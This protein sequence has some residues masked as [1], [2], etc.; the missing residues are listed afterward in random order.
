[1]K[2]EREEDDSDSTAMPPPS[3]P[4]PSTPDKFPPPSAYGETV[5]IKVGTDRTKTFTV[6]KSI[7]T[8]YSGYFAAAFRHGNAFQEA[9]TGLFNLPDEDVRTFEKFV[10]WLYSRRIDLIASDSSFFVLSRLW[11]LG[12]RRQVPLLMNECINMFRDMI[13]RMWKIPTA[14]LPLIYENTMD[15]SALRQFALDI[16]AKTGT[17][18]FLKEGNESFVKE[19]L[20]DILKI[21]WQDDHK[22]WAKHDVEK[23]QLCPQYHVHEEGVTCKKE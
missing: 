22:R 3:T 1:M 9:E 10:C 15:S 19:A 21:V 17:A 4:P 8:F 7:L 6:H 12:D 11:V 16:I 5:Q 18:K 2:R 13:V 14:C 20:I 23:L